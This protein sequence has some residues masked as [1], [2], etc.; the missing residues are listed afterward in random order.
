MLINA[1][2]DSIKGAA[3]QVAYTLMNL[4]YKGNESGQT[5]GLLGAPYYWWEAGGMFGSLIQYYH[6]TGDATY[7]NEIMQAMMWQVGPHNDYMPPNETASLG[8]DDQA[9]WAMAAMSAAENNF[10]N[11]SPG[12]PGW[13]ELAQ[14]VFN[15]QAGRWDTQFCNG[16]LRWQIYQTNTGYDLKNTISNGCFFNIAARLARY[17]GDQHYADWAVKVWDWMW[18][19]GLI[20]EAYNVYDSS[21]ADR[22][23]C[24]QIGHNQWTYNAGTMLMGASTMYNYTNGS[25][26]WRNRTAGLLNTIEFDFFPNNSG[27]MKDICEEYNA[28]NPDEKSFKAYLS[29][30][31]ASSTQMAPF[32]YNQS[33]TLLL[34]SAKAAAAQCNGG[35][36]GKLCG[37]KWYQDGKWDGT[38]GPGQQMSALEA[39]LG[40]L[41]K[42][43]VAPLTNTTGGTSPSVPT[44]GYNS[45]D[46][47]PGSIVTPATK[48]G[49]AGGWILT[50]FVS[51]LALWTWVFMASDWFEDG[52]STVA[53]GKRKRSRMTLVRDLEKMK[54]GEVLDL[55]SKRRSKEGGVAESPIMSPS[56]TLLTSHGHRRTD[57]VGVLDSIEDTIRMGETAP[58]A[59][60]RSRASDVS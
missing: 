16:G 8:N 26:L 55:S 31:M 25:D 51:V 30:W 9:F 48:P 56:A 53:G 45:S 29:R 38:D 5:P 59:K 47:P 57:S 34:A 33:Y 2:V 27:V 23:N 6:F 20:D 4:Y 46:V 50:A 49:R 7:N 52:K 24:T 15:E 17:T 28:C 42:H 13:L 32:T 19:I 22:L 37:Q 10:P 54:E 14:A 60:R 12:N 39:I 41:I 43:T 36:S 21:E 11:P 35:T 1:S 3:S 18:R 40:T 44:A 58:A